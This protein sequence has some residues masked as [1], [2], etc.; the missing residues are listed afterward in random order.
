MHCIN[1]TSPRQINSCVHINV[2]GEYISLNPRVLCVCVCGGGVGAGG[3]GSGDE[4]H[5]IVSK[6][7]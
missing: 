3:R 5:Y 7:A 4:G 6:P 1:G 2:I